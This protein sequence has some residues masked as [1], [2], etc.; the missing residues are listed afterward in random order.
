MFKG[1]KKKIVFY[2]LGKKVITENLLVIE[3]SQFKSIASSLGRTLSEVQLRKMYN[4]MKK[5]YDQ[6]K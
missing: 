5:N 1:L 4:D 3:F 2:Q 6:F